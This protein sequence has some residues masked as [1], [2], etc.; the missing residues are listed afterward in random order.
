MKDKSCNLAELESERLVTSLIIMVFG[1]QMIKKH[2][3]LPIFT[4]YKILCQRS[5]AGNSKLSQL[6]IFNFYT[7]FCLV[8]E[9]WDRVKHILAGAVVIATSILECCQSPREYKSKRE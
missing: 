4:F 5:D 3:Y 6:C 2:R 1:V 8:G 9:A 7:C